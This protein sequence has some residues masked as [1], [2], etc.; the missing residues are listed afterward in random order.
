MWWKLI[1]NISYFFMILQQKKTKVFWR[2][3]CMIVFAFHLRTLC[4]CVS[5]WG[6]PCVA[7]AK[8][9]HIKLQT[10]K[11]LF[12]HHNQTLF[13]CFI[14]TEYFII[15][16]SIYPSKAINRIIYNI[17]YLYDNPALLSY[18]KQN[19]KI[20]PIIYVKAE[21]FTITQ[22]LTQWIHNFQ[23]TIFFCWFASL[24][25]NHYSSDISD[26]LDAIVHHIEP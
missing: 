26:V 18:H 6:N 17:K 7:K 8:V 25:N 15:K 19:K 4:M 11:S 23:H 9:Y 5:S 10:T 1:Y 3:M 14:G 22:H 2:F 12:I 20:A 24:K 13:A 16:G 21:A